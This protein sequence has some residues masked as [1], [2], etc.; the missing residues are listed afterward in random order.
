[1]DS[2]VQLLFIVVGTVMLI[3][4]S[5]NTPGIH[6]RIQWWAIVLVIVVTTLRL[7]GVI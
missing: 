2:N 3:L 6:Y 5:D 7:C 4:L 1:M